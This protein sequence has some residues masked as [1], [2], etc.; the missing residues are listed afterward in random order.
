MGKSILKV[1]VLFLPVLICCRVAALAPPSNSVKF[2]RI[3]TENGLSHAV[4]YAVIQDG[5]GFLWFSTQAGLDRYDGYEFKTFQHDPNDPKSFPPSNSGAMHFEEDGVLWVGTWG[6]GLVRFNTRTGDFV[7]MRHDPD[8]P[9]SISGN[10]IQSMLMDSKNRLW[11]GTFSSGLNLLDQETGTFRRFRHIPSD[12][13]SLS[14]NRIW[15]MVQDERGYIWMGTDRGLD[16][17]NP[18]TLEFKHFS[19]DP[20]DPTSISYPVVKHIMVDPGGTLWLATGRGLTHFNVESETSERIYIDPSKDAEI[21]ANDIRVVVRDPNGRIWLGTYGYGLAV[22]DP[23]RETINLYQHNPGDPYSI[24]HNRIENIFI[25][26]T[27]LMWVATGGGGLNMLNLYPKPIQHFR[28]EF[29]RQNSLTESHVSAM[30]EDKEGHLWVGTYNSGL[31]YIDRQTGEMKYFFHDNADETSLTSNAVRALMRD[32][33]D[34]I[35]VGTYDRGLN[36]MTDEGIVT[37]KYRANSSDPFSLNHDRIRVLYEDPR[38]NVWIGTDNGLNLT[39]PDSGRFLSLLPTDRLPE[40]NRRLRVFAVLEDRRGWTWVGMDNGLLRFRAGYD[41]DGEGRLTVSLQNLAFYR[42]ESRD[43]NSLSYDRVNVLLEDSQ[44]RIWVGTEQGLNLYDSDIDGFHRY[45]DPSGTQ[46]NVIVGLME[47]SRGYLWAG[48]AVNITKFSPRTESFRHYD[49]HDGFQSGAFNQRSFFKSSRGEMFFGGTNGFNAFFPEDI[50]DNPRIPKIVLTGFKIFN[51]DANLEKPIYEIEEISVP[52]SRNMLTIEFAALDFLSP[53]K[54]RYA[55]QLNG[56][57]KDW[58]RP[59]SGRSATYTN[60]DPGEY[61]FH[62]IGSNA[63]GIWNEVGTT[64]KIQVVPPFYRTM[65]FTMLLVIFVLMLVAWRWWEIQKNTI[66]LERAVQ[67]RTLSLKEANQNLADSSDKLKDMQ[68]QMIRAA[69]QAGMAEIA[70]EIIHNIGNAL[71]SINTSADI[72]DDELKDLRLDLLERVVQLMNSF[73]DGQVP[74]EKY[75]ALL[76]ML[77]AFLDNLSKIHH[78]SVDEVDNLEQH[79]DY[80]R[81]IVNAQQR[82]AE[83]EDFYE[84]VHLESLINDALNITNAILEEFNVTVETDLEFRGE[85]RVSKSKLIQ[86]MLHVIKNGCE[87]MQDREGEKILRI[88]TS[89]REG[90]WVRVEVADTGVGIKDQ[91]LT[92]IFTYG[93]TSKAESK[94]Y[95]LH[96][97]GNAVREMGGKMGVKSKGEG[98]G[99]TFVIEFPKVPQNQTAG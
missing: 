48:T 13:N 5:I 10:R 76:K 53:S 50:Y 69:H 29:G 2:K 64:L 57:D 66:M 41:R 8:D 34:R 74:P 47:D 32:E 28:Q 97:C 33:K 51:Q 80:I 21:N 23:L 65:W 62:V 17:F 16:R 24:S 45:I 18:D 22:F 75:E 94:G 84:S 26:N 67:E 20:A 89:E 68:Q 37:Q 63:D 92:K 4:V 54:N 83:T 60:L 82:Y 85:V 81:G 38:G 73:P 25:D 58:I 90:G 7:N 79:I 98:F 39:E 95:G 1:V 43:P 72:L 27:G 55:Y 14:N 46:Y 44:G 71:N 31:N 15:H 77:S 87:A 3:N 49:S 19:H 6:S 56:F 91:D 96:F 86:I 78:R 59:L 35:W 12:R 9:T 88:H 61:T 42:H 99:S 30:V 70:V 93:Y 36:I 11:L 52:Y 40:L